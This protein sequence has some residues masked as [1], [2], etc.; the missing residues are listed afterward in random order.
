MKAG[1]ASGWIQAAEVWGTAE[2]TPMP[3][4]ACGG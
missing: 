3:V 2:G 1:R 4:G